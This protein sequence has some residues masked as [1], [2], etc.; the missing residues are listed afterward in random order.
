M[1]L[2]VSPIQQVFNKVVFFNL[3]FSLFLLLFNYSCPHFLLTL[4]CRTHPHLSH[5][6]LPQVLLSM[7]PLYMSLALTLS[8]FHQVQSDLN[9]TSYTFHKKIFWVSFYLINLC[10]TCKM[11]LIIFPHVYLWKYADGNVCLRIQWDSESKGHTR[12]PRI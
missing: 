2:S 6:V 11:W 9:L 3:K 5:S 10:F 1:F 8:G 4:P 7:C 12:M